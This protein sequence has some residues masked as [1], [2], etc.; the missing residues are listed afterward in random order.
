M[1][2]AL[3]TSAHLRRFD[4]PAADAPLLDWAIWWAVNHGVPVVPLGDRRT[5]GTL[6]AGAQ[7]WSKRPRGG[8]AACKSAKAAG[9]AARRCFE[10]CGHRLCHGVLG[11]STDVEQVVEWWTRFPRANIG[12]A[13][14]PEAGILVFE[15][16]TAHKTADGSIV[17]GRDTLRAEIEANG[18]DWPATWTNTSGGG[19]PHFLFAWPTRRRGDGKPWGNGVGAENKNRIATGVDVR[20]AGGYIVLPP[21]SSNKG[22]YRVDRMAPLAQPPGW[23]LDRIDKQPRPVAPARAAGTG[24]FRSTATGSGRRVFENLVNELRNTGSGRNQ[25]LN[26]TAHAVAGLVADP[27][28]GIGEDEARDALWRAAEANGYVGKDGLAE[29]T[30]TLDS[31]FSSGLLRPWQPD[32]RP[33]IRPPVHR[34]TVASVR[35]AVLSGTYDRED[36][37]TTFG[38]DDEQI[39][40][41]GL[42]DL[43]TQRARMAADGVEYDEDTVPA[44]A[45]ADRAQQADTVP[46]AD[47]KPQGRRRTRA[48]LEESPGDKRPR[49]RIN[50]RHLRDMYDDTVKHLLVA[51]LTDPTLFAH[52]SEALATVSP[53]YGV[54]RQLGADELSVEL[55]RRIDFV[56]VSLDEEGK[57]KDTPSDPP[58][59]VVKALLANPEK[60]GLPN[61]ARVVNAPYFTASGRLITRPGY[62]KESKVLF[63]RPR[64]GV[65][66]PE[67]PDDPSLAEVSTALDTLHEM[68]GDFPFASEA[69]RAH[70]FAMPLTLITRPMIDGP[71][72]LFAIDA[73]TEGSGK[74]L[75][76]EVTLNPLMSG[77]TVEAAPT[78]AS[79]WWKT[80]IS[81]LME[82]P[83]VVIYDNVHG[84]MDSGP[85][86]SA[87]T[88]WPL[89]SGRVLG[90]SKLVRQ[91]PP[92]VWAVSGNNI[93]MSSELTRRT[94]RVR[95]D[96]TVHGY[97]GKPS[98]RT[99]FRHPKLRSWVRENQGQ[100]IWS[101]LVVIQSWLKA[102][103]PIPD[104][105]PTMGSFTEWVE[106]VGSILDHAGIKGLLTNRNAVAAQVDTEAQLTEGF[107]FSW[108]NDPGQKEIK[109]ADGDVIKPGRASYALTAVS[110][111]DLLKMVEGLELE[112]PTKIGPMGTDR[113]SAFGRW[114]G[115]IVDKQFGPYRVTKGTAKG[116]SIYRIHNNGTK[117]QMDGD[118]GGVFIPESP[119]A[120]PVAEHPTAH[121]ATGPEDGEE[122][123]Q[124]TRDDEEEAYWASLASE[125]A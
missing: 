19:G 17:D 56:H 63:L 58:I 118:D 4:P 106:V 18:G 102:G 74:G 76:T 107:M 71:C 15:A 86:A 73:P 38:L 121:V 109:N 31:G 95:L 96:H 25:K 117:S 77:F 12:G 24:T 13:M 105:L 23:A 111:A 98:E 81:S 65:L 8:C 88:A 29:T 70:A 2:A 55:S 10:Q 11:A 34:E 99:G 57:E 42:D 16:D 78:Q 82:A 93:A 6:P 79:E 27:A 60:T 54:L 67:V 28:N 103:R 119:D 83:S 91:H 114:L 100:V 110:A 66:V 61:V 87:V 84:E 123:P 90:Q 45:P 125:D 122:T 21:S 115:S 41:V 94:V 36:A 59:R 22:V 44:P 112:L 39:A 30:T 101:W 85:L 72:P 35:K 7:D 26:D 75:F 113:R 104:N 62:D 50:A 9:L 120:P 124:A 68:Y 14:G 47:E 1:S 37:V 108:A 80:I 53:E 40:Y 32:E 69:D 48:A 20:G 5:P 97:H 43:V 64:G 52:G 51:E 46:A 49:V 3:D 92:A 33:W 116:K 89:I